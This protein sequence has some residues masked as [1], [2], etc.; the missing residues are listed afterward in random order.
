MARYE[1]EYYDDEEYGEEEY[2]EN[3]AKPGWLTETPYWAISAVLHL[4]LILT[5][6]VTPHEEPFS[7]LV[8][9]LGGLGL[10]IL[11]A[12][13]ATSFRR[14]AARVG[15]ARVKTL[16]ALGMYYL[17]GIFFYDSVL[18]WFLKAQDLAY[19]VLGTLLLGVYGMR[20]SLYLRRRSSARLPETQ[21]A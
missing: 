8:I 14:V 11:A 21:S 15:S 9:V 10:L 12:M 16:H 5:L 17:S 2:D 1:E 7:A 6:A 3:L 19:V 20:L 18:A 4:V 13:A